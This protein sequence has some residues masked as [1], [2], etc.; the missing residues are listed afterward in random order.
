MTAAAEPAGSLDTALAHTA[1]LLNTNPALAI[2]QASEI[3]KVI[4]GHPQAILMLGVGHRLSG[5]A[6]TAAEVLGTLAAGQPNSASTHFE[7][8]LALA[9]TGQGDAAVNALRRTLK[10]KPD[11]P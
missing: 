4:P 6:Q 3:L 7:L 1:R 11:H 10:L 5:N 2:E 8:S 9:A